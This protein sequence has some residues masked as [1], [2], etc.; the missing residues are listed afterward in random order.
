[1]VGVAHPASTASDVETLILEQRSP[2]GLTKIRCADHDAPRKLGAA[3]LN[4]NLNHEELEAHEG[5]GI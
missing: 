5:W 1:M 3:G 4:K 2:V